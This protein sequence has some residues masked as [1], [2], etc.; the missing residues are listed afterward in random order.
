MSKWDNLILWVEEASYKEL[1]IQLLDDAE[2]E[3]PV[4]VYKDLISYIKKIADSLAPSLIGRYFY[5]SELAK[6]ETMRPHF[7]LALEVK[8]AK[9]V[10]LIKSRINA[11]ERPLFIK[12]T[13]YQEDAGTANHPD[14]VLDFFYAGTK[15]AF[16]RISD[17]YKVGYRNNDE[18]KM[19]HCFCNQLFMPEAIFY[20]KCLRQNCGAHLQAQRQGDKISLNQ[21]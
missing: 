21:P 10:G 7:F 19:A 20:A 2:K 5:L 11:I 1:C 13:E 6:T 8:K 3:K 12:S 9:S 16:Y 14:A 18:T 17:S 15:Y 4:G